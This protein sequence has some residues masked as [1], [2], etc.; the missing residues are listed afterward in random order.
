VCSLLVQP[1]REEGVRIC[2]EEGEEG[3]KEE[4]ES[5]PYWERRK[6]EPLV[7]KKDAS[8]CNWQKSEELG[9][10]Q[11]SSSGREGKRRG[12]GSLQERG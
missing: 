6:E 9:E 1:G 7:A 11:G 10:G 4:A 8:T 12:V 3:A 2:L 5:S